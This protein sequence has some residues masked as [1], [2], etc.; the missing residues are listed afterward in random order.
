MTHPGEMAL[1]CALPKYASMEY[2]LDISA[3]YGIVDGSVAGMSRTCVCRVWMEAYSQYRVLMTD[4]HA[5][6][7]RRVRLRGWYTI[8]WIWC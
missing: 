4:D 8:G 2:G 5:L 3:A 6:E 1:E 7:V